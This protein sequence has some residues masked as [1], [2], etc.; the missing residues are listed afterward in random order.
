[1]NKQ[2]NILMV[3]V[4]V[5]FSSSCAGTTDYTL[6]PPSATKWVNVEVKNPS[7]YTRPFPLEVVYISHKCMKSSINGVDGSRE[8]KPSYNPVKI[9]LQQQQGSSLWSAKVAMTGGGPCD[10]TLSEFNLGIE[11]IDATHLGK[12]LVPGTAVG[13]TI[14]FDDIAARNGQFDSKY[15]NVNI[16]S[17]YFPYITEWRLGEN[18]KKLSLLG[19]EKFMSIR[20]YSPQFIRF[21]PE[22]N[23]RKVVR[24]IGV[25]KKIKGVYSQIVYPDGSIVSDGTV[26]PDFD[27]VD[28]I[29]I[30]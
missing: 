22:I 6:S 30:N 5:L 21:S 4:T 20:A 3:F 9:P 27:R 29:Q 17:K 8:E 25:T 1:M 18:R 26:F 23:E 13:A 28:K 2:S 24:F 12:D 11:Y 14:A 7:P 10:W 15:G 16:S 19:K